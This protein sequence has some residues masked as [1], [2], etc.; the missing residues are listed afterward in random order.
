MTKKLVSVDFQKQ[1]AALEKITEEFEAGKYSLDV[2]LKKFEEGLAL[3]SEL[4]SYLQD[5]ENRIETIKKKYHELT[6]E[7]DEGE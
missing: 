5:V 6:S 7:G 1:F 3:A 2:G 4:K